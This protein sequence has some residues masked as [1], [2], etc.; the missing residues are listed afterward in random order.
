MGNLSKNSFNQLIDYIHKQLLVL[1]LHTNKKSLAIGLSGGVDSVLL[2][3]I[4]HKIKTKFIPNLN[5]IA[6][7][8]NH[9]ISPNAKLW[10][11]FC[12][13]ICHE[14]GILID[15]YQLNIKRGGGESI[16]NIARNSRYDIFS[17]YIDDCIIVLAHHNDDQVETVISQILRGSDIHNIA[18]MKEFSIKS[19]MCLYRPLL[20]INKQNIEAYASF[21]NISHI[22]DESNT[23]EKFLRNFVRHSVIPMLY[24][25]DKHILTKI[26][27]LSVSL[28]N[29]CE[30]LD[31]VAKSDLES[32]C[33]LNNKNVLILSKLTNLSN[34]RQINVMNYYIK[35]NGLLFISKHQV[36]EF[37]RQINNSALS[38]TPSLRLTDYK[39]LVRIKNEI[40]IIVS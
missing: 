15:I 34:L 1:I 24:Q 10:E 40:K 9:N 23:D 36:R 3:H 16:E 5:I 17:K 12:G 19:N 37:V 18:G 27:N 22:V 11:K 33:D 14:L 4:L 32:I 7:H 13:D 38:S 30:L 25:Y 21:Y 29:T 26:N 35:Q 8:I 31:D 2:L 6:I 20:Q 28:Q 39:S